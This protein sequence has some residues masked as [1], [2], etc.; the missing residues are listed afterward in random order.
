[1]IEKLLKKAELEMK[2]LKHAYVGSE[3]LLLAILKEDCELVKLLGKD[4]D[5]TYHSFRKKLIENVSIGSKESET[6]LYTPLLKRLIEKL[7]E[8][9]KI[10]LEN[11]ILIILEEEEGIAYRLLEQMYIN[12]D[13]ICNSIKGLTSCKLEEFLKENPWLTDLRKYVVKKNIQI[14]G[15]ENELNDLMKV[16]LRIR[17]PNVILTGEAGVGKTALVEK[18]AIAL[19][20]GK[21]PNQLKGK[22]LI[23]LDINSCVAGTKYRGMFEERLMDAIKFLTDSDN[24]I[25]FI[26]EIHMLCDSGKSEGSTDGANALKPSLSRGD[27]M[28]IGATTSREYESSIAK[29]KA[30]QRRFARINIEEPTATQIARILEGYRD[31]FEKHY[32]IK[33][34]DKLLREIQLDAKDRLGHMPDKAI[35]MLEE[36]CIEQVYETV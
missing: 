20:E 1:M 6:T 18:L 30:L 27:V 17:K 33:I 2:E 25:L 35:D 5:L 29:D 21:V 3:H 12:L 19:N 14:T 10:K 23:Q 34:K 7:E 11:F 9:K 8:N 15:F 26:D 28:V 22:H 24:I 31:I 4:Y 16:L 36:W 32:G 13:E